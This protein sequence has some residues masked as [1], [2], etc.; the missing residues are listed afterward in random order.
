MPENIIE[1][2]NLTKKFKRFIAVDNL[3]FNV[4]KGE[5]FGFL[6][7]NGAGK[8]TTIR[9]LSTLL[10]PTSGK[11]MVSGFDIVRDA[12]KVRKKIGLVAE[13][14]II[15]DRLTAMENLEFFGRLSHLSFETI[16]KRSQKWLKKLHMQEWEDHIIGTFSTGMKQRINLI[17][18][19]LTEPEILILD[20]PTL[21]LDP[22][23]TRLIRDFLQ[24]LNQKGITII[25]TTHDMI[26]AEFLSNRVAIIDH[27]KIAALD[28]V[29]N[30]KSKVKNIKNPNL[31][32]VF[33]EIT[34]KEIRD[35]AN[36]KIKS[37]YGPR[38]AGRRF[39]KRIR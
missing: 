30:L 19:L 27:G 15:Y 5:I 13:K 1:V 11:V 21:G 23:T 12:S 33:L 26:E 34:G 17:R 32:D 20:E 22:Q 4:K 24:E 38:H 36:S 2:K 9:I 37:G 3:S 29:E 7:P 18:A 14:I 25:L 31:E 16:K 28:T 39:V 6:G 35:I 8:S 10:R